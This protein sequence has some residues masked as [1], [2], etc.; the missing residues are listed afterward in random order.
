[1]HLALLMTNTDESTFADA[2]PKDG[3]KFTDLVHLV[4]PGWTLEVFEVKNGVFPD[5]LS[6]FDGVI[7]TGS[8]ASVRGEA[9]WIERLLVL[10]R[11]IT[12]MRLPMFGACFGHQAIALALGGEIDSN[13]E[14]WAHGLIRCKVLER[15][16]WMRDL[17]DEVALYGSHIEQVVR[18]P[19]HAQA[20]MSSPGCAFAGFVID[21]HIYTTQHHPEMSPAFIAAL[22]EEMA[23]TLGDKAKSARASLAAPAATRA[24]AQSI[25]RFFQG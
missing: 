11:E 2:H 4:R 1:M 18:L 22:T 14:G 13:P 7:I 6:R 24:F 20:I 12:A 9:P 23:E 21:R 17:P 8:P 3:E 25:A 10:I 5:D 16:D 15:T 19:D